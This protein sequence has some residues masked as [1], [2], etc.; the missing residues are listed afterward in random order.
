MVNTVAYPDL[1][2]ARFFGYDSSEDP[3]EF[4]HLLEEKISFSLESRPTATEN[5]Q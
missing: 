3:I 5:G 2:L 1:T 4:I